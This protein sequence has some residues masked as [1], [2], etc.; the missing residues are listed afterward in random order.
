MSGKTVFTTEAGM[1]YFPNNRIFSQ[2]KEIL[3][4]NQD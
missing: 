4:E 2:K 1:Q 3:N